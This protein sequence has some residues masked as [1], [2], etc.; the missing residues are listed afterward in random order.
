VIKQVKRTKR[1]SLDTD[2][3]A[4]SSDQ[5][6]PFSNVPLSMQGI[7]YS[8]IDS[9]ARPDVMNRQYKIRIVEKLGFMK[10]ALAHEDNTAFDNVLPATDVYDG[11]DGSAQENHMSSPLTMMPPPIDML[12]EGDLSKLSDEELETMID[13]YVSTVVHE[14]VHFATF[15]EDFKTEINSLDDRGFSLLH[16][17]SLYDL[18]SLISVLVARGAEVEQLTASG[19]TSLH[20]AAAAGHVAATEA[21]LLNG[22]NVQARDIHGMTSIDIAQQRGFEEVHRML[23]E[24]SGDH[25]YGTILMTVYDRYRFGFMSLQNMQSLCRS[26]PTRFLSTTSVASFSPDSRASMERD[27]GETPMN[28]SILHEVFASLSLTDKCALSLSFK[29]QSHDAIPIL[30][31]VISP[32]VGGPLLEYA[33][34]PSQLSARDDKKNKD[35]ITDMLSMQ[36]N[37]SL[38]KA[39][40]LMGDYERQQVD[41]EVSSFAPL[42]WTPV[43]CLFVD[44]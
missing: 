28:S 6:S 13:K 19:S 10:S 32:L 12:D 16:Y 41:D 34:E 7:A 18:T 1:K 8:A 27:I 29:Q 3:L 17:C 15:D 21:L 31:P 22:A 37:E 14:L 36:D 42:R 26:S 25:R 40:Q 23:T 43:D 38:E 4:P 39:M 20:L 5:A 24:V 33:T 11:N 35:D 44:G 9:S 2:P 30:F